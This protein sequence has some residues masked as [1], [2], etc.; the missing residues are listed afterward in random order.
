MAWGP[1]PCR[2]I[3]RNPRVLGFA[4][5]SRDA[6]PEPDGRALIVSFTS[7]TSSCGA[8]SRKRTRRSE[9][10]HY[11]RRSR[12][13]SQVAAILALLGAQCL[14]THRSKLSSD[15]GDEDHAPESV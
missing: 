5:A 7:A 9:S 12:H 4:G 13:R 2:T 3:W 6:T 8:A 1:A 11:R 15:Q 10:L 14:Q